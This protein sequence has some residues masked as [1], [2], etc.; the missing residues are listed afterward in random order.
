MRRVLKAMAIAFVLFGI[1]LPVPLLAQTNDN[2]RTPLGTRI[3]KDRQFPYDPPP[4]HVPPEKMGKATRDW[5]RAMLSQF[6]KC[7]YNRS[8]GDSL[9]LLDKTDFGFRDFQQIGM[10]TPKAVRI[11]GFDDCLRRVA[12]SNG[13][14]VLLT[15]SAMGLRMWLIQAAYLDRFPKGP[16]WLTP[17]NVVAPRSYP[18]SEQYGGIK[19]QMDFAD[20]V[21]AADPNNADYFYRTPSGSAEEQDALTTLTPAFAPCFPQGVQARFSPAELRVLIGEGLWQAANHSAAPTP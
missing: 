17:G 11:Y 6:G 15:Y 5:S 18:L 9:D 1:P 3:K 4:L 10:E 7:L 14:G 19:K 20:C 13:S 2:D 21:V 12:E 8:K 16:A